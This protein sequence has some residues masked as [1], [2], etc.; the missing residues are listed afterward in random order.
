MGIAIVHH[1]PK[2][3]TSSSPTKFES[4]TAKTSSSGNLT[5]TFSFT[6]NLVIIDKYSPDT[7]PK[8]ATPGFIV[9]QGES[10]SF[11]LTEITVDRSGVSCTLS[12]ATLTI[13]SNTITT[14]RAHA[15]KLI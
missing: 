8:I 11:C 5:F 10:I 13:S 4:K 9:M 2:P 14:Y 3:Q 15:I 7:R 6:P 12:G 1:D